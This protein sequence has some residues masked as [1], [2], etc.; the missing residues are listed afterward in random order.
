M[1]NNWIYKTT[2]E[3]REEAMKALQKAKELETIKKQT[4]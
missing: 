1:N 2:K 4:K 3:L